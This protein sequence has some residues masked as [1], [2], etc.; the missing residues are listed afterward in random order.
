MLIFLDAIVFMI[1]AM[2]AMFI[3]VMLAMAKEGQQ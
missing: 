3:F 2:Q 1:P